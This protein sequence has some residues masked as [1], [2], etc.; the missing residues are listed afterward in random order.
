MDMKM[1]HDIAMTKPTRIVIEFIMKVTWLELRATPPHLHAL[2]TVETHDDATGAL[3]G[4]AHAQ[5]SSTA[6]DGAQRDRARA[7]RHLIY[8]SEVPTHHPPLPIPKQMR[9]E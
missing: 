1:G 3:T 4:L 6:E 2:W 7:A 8:S 9:S 5:R